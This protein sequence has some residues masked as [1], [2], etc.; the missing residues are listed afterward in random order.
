[1]RN[2]IDGIDPV[3]DDAKAVRES[4]EV[5]RHAAPKFGR[6]RRAWVR[7]KPA[8]PATS[9]GR[10][11]IRSRFSMIS[12]SA[13]GTGGLAPVARPPAPGKF[14]RCALARAILRRA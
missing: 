10:T 5:D 13:A 9:L 7:R 3:G 8:I 14:A 1:E 11:V 6:A 2:R 12:P 4:G